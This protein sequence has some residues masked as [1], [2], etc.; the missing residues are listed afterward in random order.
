MTYRKI[1]DIDPELMSNDI[2]LKQ[3]DREGDVNLYAKTLESA[4]KE[5]LEIHASQKMKVI[6]DRTRQPWF[7][8]DLKIQKKKDQKE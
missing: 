1:K 2:D 6:K 7:D 8:N 5:A 3:L 4:L